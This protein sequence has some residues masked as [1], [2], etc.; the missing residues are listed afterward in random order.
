MEFQCVIQPESNLYQ[1]LDMFCSTSLT[2]KATT[3]VNTF[4]KLL[5]N[6]VKI[7]QEPLFNASERVEYS[8]ILC[9]Q[10][11]LPVSVSLRA[12]DKVKDRHQAVQRVKL[13]NLLS[14][15]PALRNWSKV[16]VLTLKLALHL[17][18]TLTSTWNGTGMERSC[19]MDTA[20]ELSTILELLFWTF[21]TVMKKIQE[22]LNAEHQ[23]NME[24]IPPKQRSSAFQRPI[25]FWTRNYQE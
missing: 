21:C 2:F 18:T 10:T 14:I 9:N 19:H 25:L 20:T 8:L 24:V 6:T 3:R 11:L 1:T 17:S 13:P 5:T 15:L 16:K 4:A 7:I 23:T 12:W 22:N